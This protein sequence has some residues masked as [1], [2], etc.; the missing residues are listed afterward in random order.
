M[1]VIIRSS[2][3]MPMWITQVDLSRTTR[4]R[5]SQS[6]LQIRRFRVR[7]PRRLGTPAFPC[8]WHQSTMAAIP[9]RATSGRRHGDWSQ[10][11]AKRRR[12]RRVDVRCVGLL[13]WRGSTI[14]RPSWRR[15]PHRIADR[16]VRCYRATAGRT[17][18][19]RC[20]CRPN[21]LRLSGA[22]PSRLSWTRHVRC[23]RILARSMPQ[24]HRDPN[25]RCSGSGCGNDRRRGDP[26]CDC[27]AKVLFRLD[28]VVGGCDR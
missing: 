2:P 27:A 4:S 3:V 19:R 28:D 8:S 17:V 25:P 12:A 9:A 16:W 20:L 1:Q 22:G 24:R 15:S 26:W 10:D 11:R 7:R 6:A 14:R 13:P 18:R 23:T 21:R 5:F